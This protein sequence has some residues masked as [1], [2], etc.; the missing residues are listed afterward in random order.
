MRLKLLATVAAACLAV[1]AAQA[2]IIYNNGSPTASSGNEATWWVQ[3][4]DFSFAAGATVGGAGVY[5]AGYRGIGAWDGAF[6]YW[7]FAD[8]GG[9]PGTIL[10]T[11]SVTP[12]VTNSGILWCCGGNA[13]L[14]AFD[15]AS[16]FNAAAGVTY[17]LG[18][19][20]AKDFNS[21]DE[22][23]WV[24]TDANATASGQESFLGTFT[25]WRSNRQEHAFYLTGLRE[26]GVPEPATLGLLGLG[27]LGLGLAARRRNA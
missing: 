6:R 24:T 12:T 9:K 25:N 16:P 4:Q 8:G 7:I 2:T 27:L 5:L 22:I 10:A 19:H 11:G 21:R 26:V 17:W 20:A 13:F 1:P 3:A 18:I 15:L 23:Y 14:F